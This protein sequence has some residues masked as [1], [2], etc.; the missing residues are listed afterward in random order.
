MDGGHY[1]YIHALFFC[2]HYEFTFIINFFI[3]I[4]II[5]DRSVCLSVRP[6]SSEDTAGGDGHRQ[7][8]FSR[9][10]RRLNTHRFEAAPLLGLVLCV[11]LIP[12]GRCQISW[13][14][15]RGLEEVKTNNPEFLP[16][17]G[18]QKL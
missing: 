7:Y 2:I 12:R 13:K 9:K 1:V 17:L 3:S 15:F 16:G 8:L 14:T 6:Q 4:E 18:E 11:S 10:W 5:L